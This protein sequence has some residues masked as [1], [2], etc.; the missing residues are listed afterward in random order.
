VDSRQRRIWSP[1]LSLQIEPSE[2]GSILNG[3]FSPRPDIWTLLMFLY[4]TIL[5]LV[6][7]GAMLGFAQ[8][9]IGQT[10]WGFVAVAVGLPLIGLLHLASLVGQQL[11]REQM[12]ELRSRLD[13]ALQ[14]TFGIDSSDA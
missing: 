11:G 8:R 2:N 1:H 7:F 14:M 4:F 3:R 10:A 13:A 6:F 5:T 9:M 12:A